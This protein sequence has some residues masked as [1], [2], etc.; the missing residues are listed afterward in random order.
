MVYNL[1]KELF[2][3]LL[4]IL[5]IENAVFVVIETNTAKE[6]FGVIGEVTVEDG[7]VVVGCHRERRE[8]HGKGRDQFKTRLWFVEGIV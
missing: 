4:V 1:W 6:I 7:G 2:V 8:L 3:F 5:L